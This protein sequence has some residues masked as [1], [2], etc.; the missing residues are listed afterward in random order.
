MHRK[1]IQ[2]DQKILHALTNFAN[3]HHGQMNQFEKCGDFAIGIDIPKKLL[4]FT[5]KIGTSY[6]NKM[7]NLHDIRQCTVE[8]NGRT[9]TNHY[10]TYRVIDSL[11]LRF[12]SS[13]KNR[14]DSVLHFFNTSDNLQLSGELQIIEQWSEL[15]NN[16]IKS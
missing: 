1:N 4:F 8:N 5:K 12:I 14:D 2:A 9:I 16:V 3:L 13:I 7:I 11:D 6:S 10:V 15:I